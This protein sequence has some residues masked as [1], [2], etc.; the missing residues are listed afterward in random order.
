MKIKP[1]GKLIILILIVGVAVGAWRLWGKIAPSAPTVSSG[2]PQVGS[3]PSG[4]MDSTGDSGSVSSIP[5]VQSLNGGEVRLLGYAWNAQM[6]LMYANGGPTST[7]DSIM[8]KHDV[9]LHFIRQDDYGKMQEALDA[10]ATQL[11]Q[12]NPNPVKGAH[13]VEIMGDGSAAFLQGLND[14]LSKLGPGYQAKIV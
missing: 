10:F 6:G 11:S 2:V 12:G 4:S 7:Q 9:N 5:G 13:F 3:L 8:H 14:T 1:L